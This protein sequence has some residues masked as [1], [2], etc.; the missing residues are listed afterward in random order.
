[1]S[2]EK[3]TEPTQVFASHTKL[4]SDFCDR[5]DIAAS[6]EG[7]KVFRSELEDIKNPSWSTIRSAINKSSALFL[8]VGK[9]LVEMQSRT[10]TDLKSMEE[11]KFTQNWIA[12]EIGV[13]CQFGID[14]WVWCDDVSIN[15]PVPYLNNYDAWGIQRI[16]KESLKFARAVFSDYNRKVTFHLHC[17]KERDRTFECPHCGAV[18]NLHSVIPELGEIPCPTCLANLKFPKGWLLEV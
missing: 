11:W 18:F 2:Q 13:A 12:F 17:Y 1:M 7:V 4:D 6:R 5:F 8:L 16:D 3:V 14:V 15:F 10:E 9:R